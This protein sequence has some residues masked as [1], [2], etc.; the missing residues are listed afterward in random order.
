MFFIFDQK[1][2][3]KRTNTALT[4]E[5]MIL[6]KIFS[7]CFSVSNQIVRQ[8]THSDLFSH[9]DKIFEKHISHFYRLTIY[10]TI[11]VHLDMF[12]NKQL[13]KSQ[14]SIMII[15]AV[16]M[17]GMVGTAH[18]WKQSRLR[19]TCGHCISF[20]YCQ[21]FIRNVVI[22]ISQTHN[23]ISTLSIHASNKTVS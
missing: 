7:P 18:P 21:H 6:L 9:L 8:I 1:L 13:L 17:T 2:T 14:V 12:R 4:N 15:I 10:L 20:K 16:W 3:I 5:I 23:Q 11:S 22:I 19:W